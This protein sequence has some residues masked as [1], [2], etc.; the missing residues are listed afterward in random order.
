M[1]HHHEWG[2]DLFEGRLEE[3]TDEVC[4]QPQSLERITSDWNECDDMAITIFW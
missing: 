3:Q 4:G 1:A 2:D